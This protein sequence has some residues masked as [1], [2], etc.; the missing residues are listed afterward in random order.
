M[1]SIITAFLA[2]P[3]ALH[4]EPS[5]RLAEQ[6]SAAGEE[7]R[8]DQ[9]VPVLQPEVLGAASLP[10]EP[11][12]CP[13]VGERAAHPAALRLAAPAGDSAV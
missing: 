7:G 12:H 13:A 8:L 10:F 1:P 9:A 6:A 5:S 3:F 2:L 11:G 4:L